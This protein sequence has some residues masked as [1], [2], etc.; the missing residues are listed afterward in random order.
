MKRST[1]EKIQHALFDRT[2]SPYALGMVEKIFLPFAAVYLAIKSTIGIYKV[3]MDRRPDEQEYKK[4]YQKY[5]KN[6][7]K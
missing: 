4:N 2:G 5:K 6:Y 7:Q 3:W 1:T